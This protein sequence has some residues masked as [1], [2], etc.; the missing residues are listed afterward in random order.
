M[1]RLL[2]YGDSNTWGQAQ[3]QVGMSKR[4][5][6]DRQWPQIL[7][8]LLFNECLIIQEGLGG[9]VAGDFDTEKS[10]YNGKTSYEVV[11][12]SAAPVDLVIIALGTN[13]LKVRY[14]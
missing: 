11:L 2:C 3:H 13:D 12:R 5:A 6:S 1:K 7:Q 10:Y 14:E 4:I 9:R 8:H